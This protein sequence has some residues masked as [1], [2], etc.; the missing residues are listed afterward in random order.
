MKDGKRAVTRSDLELVFP[1]QSDHAHKGTMGRVLLVCGSY[2]ER[3]TAMC[4]AAY[5]S[6]MA[7]YRTGAGIVELFIPMENYAPLATLVPEAVFSL[8]DRREN[9]SE[10]LSRLERS[11]R[12]ANAVVIGCGLGKSAL[13]RQL[14]R[15]VLE[16]A[17][18]P[19]LIDADGLN[20]LSEEAELWELP[21]EEQRRRTA[22]TPHPGEMF[23]IS[24]WDAKDICADPLGAAREISRARGVTCLLKLHETLTVSRAGVYENH[25][26]NPGMATGGMGDILAGV[27]GALL[28]RLADRHDLTDA[29][30]DE[31][32]L[33]LVAVG[34]HIHGAAGDLAARELGEYGMTARDVLSKIP[35]AI[36]GCFG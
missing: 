30:Y 27:I 17:D 11:M 9:F 22:I 20:L 5:L 1:K 2:D 8:Y 6:A 34:A 33:R 18:V 14:L 15:A 3:G 23:R 35:A 25:T 36:V 26:G 28:A 31:L 13:S 21:C 16:K 24:P 12:G 7:A 4:G 29:E 32:F 19:L 10:I